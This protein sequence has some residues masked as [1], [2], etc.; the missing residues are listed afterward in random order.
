MIRLSQLLHVSLLM[1]RT[2]AER[3]ASIHLAGIDLVALSL[4]TKTIRQRQLHSSLLMIHPS[5]GRVASTHSAGI[6]LV[7]TAIR[8]VVRS[9]ASIGGHCGNIRMG[10]V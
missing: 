5:A 8:V 6:D 2:S 1:I 4:I 10:T 9:L 7:A 3:M